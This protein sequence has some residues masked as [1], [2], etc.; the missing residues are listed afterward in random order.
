MSH[1]GKPGSL[2]Y[3]IDAL[4]L[5]AQGKTL[6]LTD[7]VELCLADGRSCHHWS[8]S[9]TLQQ[10]TGREQILCV[11]QGK[12]NNNIVYKKGVLEGCGPWPNLSVDLPYFQLFLRWKFLHLSAGDLAKLTGE[13]LTFSAW[14]AVLN[15]R[16]FQRNGP[17]FLS[18]SVCL[19]VLLSMFMNVLFFNSLL[20][21]K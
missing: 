12:K 15:E 6:R 17:F 2:R 5:Y 8:H 3:Q 13:P 14:Q 4:G 21:A 20:N 1:Y 18:L 10:Q 16:S 7:A 11:V 9:L 19:S